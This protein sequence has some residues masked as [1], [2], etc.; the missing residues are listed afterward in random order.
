MK[1]SAQSGWAMAEINP[2]IRDLL[3]EAL[4]RR[5]PWTWYPAGTSDDR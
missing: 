2:Q 3:A 4:E 5:L 1:G